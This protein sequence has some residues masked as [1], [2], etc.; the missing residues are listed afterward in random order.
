VEFSSV[1]SSLEYKKTE[2][3]GEFLVR[4]H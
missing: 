4:L 2:L 1:S 3:G